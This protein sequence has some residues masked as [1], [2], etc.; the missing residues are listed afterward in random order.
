[1]LAIITEKRLWREH[2]R[3]IKIA[4]GL[5]LPA[6]GMNL[7]ILVGVLLFMQGNYNRF[8]CIFAGVVVLDDIKIRF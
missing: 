3:D 7:R 1:M 2:K 4:A 8:F 5:L 6:A